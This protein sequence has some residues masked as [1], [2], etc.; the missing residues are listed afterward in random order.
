[1][2]T[3][4]NILG[5]SRGFS[6]V[7][8]LA[9]ITVL[10]VG[11]L[12]V[13]TMQRAAVRQNQMAFAEQTATALAEQLLEIARGMTYKNTLLT[14]TTGYTDPPSSVSP[15]NPLN[16]LG[17]NQASG[18]YTRTWKIT[19]NPTVDGVVRNNVKEVSVRVVWTRSGEIRRVTVSTLKA[20]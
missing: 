9:A 19:E 5:R 6:L 20:K 8:V 7:E 1:M 15:A 17:A 2:R 10:A 4:R 16:G 11:A 3:G 14:V 13:M 18:G 12:A